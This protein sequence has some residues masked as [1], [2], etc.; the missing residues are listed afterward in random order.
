MTKPNRKKKSDVELCKDFYSK[1]RNYRSN[2]SKIEYNHL[3][4]QEVI[5]D[6][7]GIKSA[8]M[9]EV[10]LENSGDPT[11]TWKHELVDKKDMLLLQ[12]ASLLYDTYIVDKVLFDVSEEI[13][14]MITECYI[15]RVKKHDDIA[16]DYKRS[17]PTMYADMNRAVINELKK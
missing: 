17:K 4:Y 2:L 6:M 15:D 16:H 10:I 5:N 7:Y 12:R 14:K 9:K 13:E 1:C 3:R 11:H 8:T